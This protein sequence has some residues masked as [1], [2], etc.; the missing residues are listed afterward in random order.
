MSIDEQ[1]YQHMNR[2]TNRFTH[3]PN[4][5]DFAGLTFLFTVFGRWRS[6]SPL[7]TW[8]DQSKMHVR[9]SNMSNMKLTTRFE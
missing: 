7:P 5:C 1:L 8:M 4:L 6:L 2:L 3:V 9:A